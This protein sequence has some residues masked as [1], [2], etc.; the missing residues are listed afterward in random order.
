MNTSV[1]VE[2]LKPYMIDAD[3][4]VVV[5]LT[6]E[7]TLYFA[8]TYIMTQSSVRDRLEIAVLPSDKEPVFIGCQ[9]ERV[10]IDKE[11]WINDRR[12]YVEFQTSPIAMLV[13]VLKEKGYEN[14]KIG[15][16]LDYLAACYYVELTRSLPGATFIEIRNMCERVRMIKEPHEIEILTKYTRITLGALERAIGETHPGETELDFAK[17]VRVNL[18]NSGASG[19]FM[20]T[21][22]GEK[23]RELHKQPD[24]TILEDG[25]ILRIDF[26]GVFEGEYKT[27]TGRVMMIGTPNPLHEKEFTKFCEA[28]RKTVEIMKPGIMASEIY[29]KCKEFLKEQGQELIVPHIG[30]SLGV[31]YHEFPMLAARDDF[32]LQENMI[33]CVEPITI[34]DNCLYHIEDLILITKNGHEV[35]SVPHFDP[36]MLYIK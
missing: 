1:R 16:E 7:N 8:E 31:T 11:T 26:G 32:P 19:M 28:Y 36:K 14:A 29:S 17:R 21:G 13:E 20:V 9:A 18:I 10:I 33:F 34:V 2:R 15:I 23:T 3:L 24:D 6:P 27:D 30:H 12:Y 4:D 22:T 25:K 35:V 5:I